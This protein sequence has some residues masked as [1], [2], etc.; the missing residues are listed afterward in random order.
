M[1]KFYSSDKN[2]FKYSYE[3]IKLIINT[4][5]NNNHNYFTLFELINKITWNLIRDKSRKSG[6]GEI[7]RERIA[8][9]EGRNIVKRG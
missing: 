1:K 4:N 2:N 7:T 5:I 9:L 8:R 6:T 3:A